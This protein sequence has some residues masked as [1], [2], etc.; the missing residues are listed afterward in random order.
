VTREASQHPQKAAGVTIRAVLIGLLLI[1]ASNHWVVLVEGKWISYPTWIIPFVNV[2]FILFLLTLLNSLLKSFLPRIALNQGELMVSYVMLS[3]ATA[4]CGT[5]SIHLLIPALGHLFWFATPENDWAAL[6]H[7]YIPR[8]LTIQDKKILRGFYEGDSSFYTIEHLKGWILPLIAWFAFI[9]ALLFVMICAN[10]IVRKRWCETEK[11]TFPIIQLPV[12]MTSEGGGRKFFSSRLMWIGFGVV[13]GI[14]ISAGLHKLYPVVPALE[15]NIADI[16]R[17]FTE[18]PFSAIGW[19]PVIISPF[20]VGIGFLIPVDL[21]FSCCFFYLFRKTQMVLTGMGGYSVVR[22]A[23]FFLEQRTGAW[24]GLC[25]ISLWMSRMHLKEVMNTVLGRKSKLDD[26]G[27]P[28]SYR[29]AIVGIIGGVIFLTLFLV[30]A[31]MSL[32]IPPF[33]LLIY[34]L[35]NIGITRARAELGPPCHYVAYIHPERVITQIFGTRAFNKESLTVAYYLDWLGRGYRSTPMPHVLE[36][37]RIG[38]VTKMN[39]K[40][41]LYALLLAVFVGTLASFWAFSDF[42]YKYTAFGLEGVGQAGN[43]ANWLQSSMTYPQKPEYLAVSF[44]GIGFVFTLF[45]TLMRTRFLWW[46][47]HPVGYAM[48]EHLT[49]DWLWAPFFISLVVKVALLK[50]KG[51]K[52]YREGVPF[53][54]GLILGDYTIRSIWSIISLIIGKNITVLEMY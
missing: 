48:A 44:I 29:A 11:L 52:G 25:V 8:W 54:M 2:I 14:G 36:A 35:L 30:R 39:N 51:I 18:K 12:E 19:T 31:G 37:F 17:Y 22:G 33:W 5:D 43:A 15:V 13:T 49:M 3:I 28:I 53:F 40:R 16:G 9:F 34:F 21:L 6:F 45:L 4:L 27:E 1:P 50:Y 24:I 42:S 10:A 32:W 23:P 41:L 38:T 26:S 46:P 7:K 47:F 20:A